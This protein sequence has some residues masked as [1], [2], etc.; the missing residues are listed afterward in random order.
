MFDGFIIKA[1]AY[2]NVAYGCNNR[3][4]YH[5]L[6]GKH[7]KIINKFSLYWEQS[8]NLPSSSSVL[9]SSTRKGIFLCSI[10][11]LA[12]FCERGR[13]ETSGGSKDTKL[14]KQQNNNLIFYIEYKPE[15]L[16]TFVFFES[17]DTSRKKTIDVQSLKVIQSN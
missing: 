12:W 7:G 5:G 10:N 6:L 13:K 15:A 14:M 3:K 1:V 11:N 4:N 9:W 8:A 2:Q 17:N 16:K